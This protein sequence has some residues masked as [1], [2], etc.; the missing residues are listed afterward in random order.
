MIDIGG[1]QHGPQREVPAPRSAKHAHATGVHIG[2]VASQRLERSHVVGYLVSTDTPQNHVLEL[3][4]T[5]GRTAPVHHEHDGAQ[6]GQPLGF[7][8]CDVVEP[9]WHDRGPRPGIQPFDDG[10][11]L[12]RIEVGRPEQSPV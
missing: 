3:L 4:P 10:V 1:E 7:P 8:G 2:S 11:Q 6:P 12:A 5:P 9:A